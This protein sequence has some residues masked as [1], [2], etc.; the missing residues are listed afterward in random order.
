M[1]LLIFVQYNVA[2][3]P[4][5]A[6]ALFVW[7]VSSEFKRLW[8]VSGNRHIQCDGSQ[9]GVLGEDGGLSIWGWGG[10]NCIKCLKKEW[11]GKKGWGNKNFKKGGMLGKSVGALKREGL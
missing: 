4:P 1:P 2:N 3:F 10:G 9:V 11:N 7:F 8:L 5:L 6:T